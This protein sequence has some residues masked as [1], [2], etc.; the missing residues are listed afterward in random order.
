VVL[1]GHFYQPPR[2]DPWL[3]VVEQEP[4]AAP[5]HDWNARIEQDCYRAVVAARRYGDDG[6]IA[7]IVNTLASISFDFGPTLLEWLERQA[8]GTYEAI[9]TADKESVECY[10]GHGNAMAMPYHHLILPLASRRDKVTEVRWG[11][12]DFRRRFRR[13]PE[14]MWLPETAVD[15]ETLDVLAA[16]GIRFTVLAPHQIAGAPVS[17]LPGKYRT[18][19]GR[20]I[21]LCT[22]DGPI[23]QGIAFG[24]LLRDGRVW[25]DRLLEPDRTGSRRRVVAVATDGETYG[26]HHRFGE[27]TLAWLIHA[28]EARG[29]IRVENFA[30]ILARHPAQEEVE[31]NAPSSWSC[32]H[33]VERWRSDCDCRLAPAPSGRLMHW[34]APL[35]EALD[36]LAAELH[37]LYE[38]EGALLFDD[39]WAVRDG[40]GE[41][42]WDLAA[43]AHFVSERMHP[44]QDAETRVRA[45]ELLEIEWAALAM[46]TSCG[47]FFDDI[48]GIETV[49]ILRYAARAIELAGNDARRLEGG[50]LVRLGRAESDRAAGTGRDLYV[51]RVVPRIP[52]A[53]GVAAGAIAARQLLPD[54]DA[55]CGAAVQVRVEGDRAVVVERRTSRE[56]A[57][58]ASCRLLGGV[59]IGLE[60]SAMDGTPVAGLELDD[61][62]ECYR[63]PIIAALRSGVIEHR[64]TPDER[65]HLATGALDAPTVTAR[66]LGRAVRALA[67]DHS[68]EAIAT[69]LDLADLLELFGLQV[70]FDA[71]TAFNRIRGAASPREIESLAPVAARLGFTGEV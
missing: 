31:L 58:R 59:R 39:P 26:H 27:V 67:G 46:F 9:L 4:S 2:E 61:L 43:A 6:R 5:F 66:A 71:Q 44:P 52:I 63:L 18:E 3:E 16:E 15:E 40:Y 14:G 70:P 45:H 1:H 19:G 11:I 29:D 28:L 25:G 34:R 21:A 12:A 69:V 64:F 57:F 50:L 56:G 41:H 38:R 68:A 20:E 42:R 32:A 55:T 53:A 17:G 7:A 65:A 62:P 30:S 48:S 24:G 35:R 13:E 47:W 33:G 36:W 54:S 60:V 51:E 23:S 10:G 49:Q 22:Y 37:G 8:P